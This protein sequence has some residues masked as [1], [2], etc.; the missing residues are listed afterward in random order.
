MVNF[1][2]KKSMLLVWAFL[3]GITLSW[4]Q[5]SVARQWDEVMLNCIRK[6][7]ARPTVQAHRLCHAGIVMWDAW[8]V[9]DDNS[10]PFLLGNT[11]GGFT[12]PF[13]GIAIPEDVQAAQE[14]CIS[15]AMYR[16]LLT[17]YAG[18]PAGNLATVQGYINTLMTSLE[19][20]PAITS[21]DYSDGDPAKLGNYI[22][23]QMQL[24][25]LQDGSN[26]GN[27][28]A[29]QYYQPVNGQLQPQLPGNPNC[30]DPNRWQT[31]CL[32][33]QCDQAFPDTCVIIPCSAPA[34]THEFGNVNPFCM[35]ET[36][37]TIHQ[38]DGHDWLVYHDPGPPPLLD[39]NVQTGLEDPYKWGYVLNSVW[40]SMHTTEDGVMIDISP[41]SIGNVLTYPQSVA[42]YPSFYDMFNGGDT[43]EGYDINPATG[44]PYP[45]QIVP[46][47]DYTRVLS[48]YWAD[49]PQSETP[50]GHWFKLINEV[51]DHPDH[52]NLWEGQGELIDDLEWDVRCYFT[53]G[54]GILDAAIACWGA[55]GYYD[56]TRPIMAIR[57]MCDFGQS[58]D[59]Q[60]PNYHPAGIPLLPG[61]VELVETG[62]P[63][64]GDN[65]ENVGKIKL[66]TWSGPEPATGQNGVQWILG[67]NW[68]TYQ[69][70]TFVTPPFAGYYSGHS[71]Y[72]RTAA[73]ILT[74][75][76]GDEYFPGGM[77]EFVAQPNAYL[78]AD[79][80]PSVEVK[81]Q[82]AKYRDASD[83][84]SLSRIFGGL[85]PPQDDIPGRMVGSVVGPEAFNKASDFIE[86]GYPHVA[87]VTPS[88]VLI[89]D[90]DNN[91]TFT[92]TIEFTKV[93]DPAFIPVVAYS[94]DDPGA[95]LGTST[96]EW[97]SEST[98]VLTYTIADNEETLSNVRWHVSEARDLNGNVVI[99]ASSQPV[100][101][102]TRNP[103]VEEFV[104][105]ASSLN[106]S[107]VG[108]DQM[109][110][111][112]TF[113]EAMDV[114]T[115][116]SFDF[117][118]ASLN[119]SFILNET[120]SMWMDNMNYMA[121]FDLID[122]DDQFSDVSVSVISATDAVG[123]LQV[124]N[125]Q[126]NVFDI[127]T[128]EPTATVS[129]DDNA[130]N[131]LDAV[132]NVLVVSVSFDETMD[133]Q[134]V[135]ELN[136]PAEDPLT[137]G[138]VLNTDLSGWADDMTYNFVFDL[139][140]QNAELYDIDIASASGTDMMGNTQSGTLDADNLDIDTRAP[141]VANTTSNDALIADA[142]E[143]VGSWTLD[144]TFDELMNTSVT[145]T[146]SFPSEDP[147]STISLNGESTWDA[148]Q[149]TYHASFDVADANIELSNV[150][151]EVT[152]AADRLDNTQ[153]VSETSDYFSIDTRNPEVELFTANDYEITD[154]NEGQAAFWLVAI[155]DEAMDENS[156]PAFSF[157][158][159]NPSGAI[160][161]NP[162]ES[163]WLNSMTYVAKYNVANVN[164]TLLD[165]DVNAAGLNDLAGNDQV[166]IL[167]TDFFDIQLGVGI[168]EIGDQQVLVYPN[169]VTSG[170]ELVVSMD[171]IPS[172][173]IIQ[174]INTSG[175]I[176]ATPSNA[177]VAGNQISFDTANLAAGMYFVNILSDGGNATF[178]VQIVK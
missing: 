51:N 125:D 106:Q 19:Y 103:L 73:E 80:G 143:G 122:N 173:M 21:T 144:I 62:D 85:H 66:Y 28:Y 99:P 169:P 121:V 154:E 136:F 39:V 151:I 9:Y 104:A 78:L 33:L 135:P 126:V 160:T 131:E 94:N 67:E 162:G 61:F 118:E 88:D 138:L 20:D 30:Y 76:T 14:E 157:P 64:A 115:T 134:V 166:N 164:F 100:M 18:V 170:K 35:T 96:G 128:N 71:T 123:N 140:D 150:D 137:A 36:D 72:S 60:L 57:A 34:L 59:S 27:N 139:L 77:G 29:N 130:L 37:L 48:E 153:E 86:N 79:A 50:P 116:P 163:D 148:D 167:Y 95:T 53:L 114:N 82:W 174:L 31:L 58:T 171:Q 52:Q 149:M 2:F 32:N 24:Y 90:I 41:N 83:Q 45:E 55:K 152:G 7:G 146:I 155:F 4:S 47:G 124:N 65:D 1:T 17:R 26:M 11:W 107:N 147:S 70:H 178:K 92:V 119:L 68:W 6:D 97:I 69:R 145:P 10:Q 38:R 54:G 117:S 109:T 168:Y 23:A 113:D 84:C 161:F 142:N 177:N 56:Y 25:A 12:V 156:A 110:F 101:V 75:I 176:V 40:H 159:E 81:L 46:R 16:F 93:M 165:I 5:Q 43:G 13:D 132:D 108:A 44:M 8:A 98:Y 127:D 22:A 112:V 129:L 91:Q 63:L 175:Q 111:N 158:S 172:G 74:L 15:Y 49:G 89:T 105:S 141:L 87:G 120:S 102:D 42:E 133:Q 3:G